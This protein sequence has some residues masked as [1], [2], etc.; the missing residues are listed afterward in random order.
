MIT[1]GKVGEGNV[2]CGE[3][4]GRKKKALRDETG[5]ILIRRLLIISGMIYL[6]ALPYTKEI[7]NTDKFYSKLCST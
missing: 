3:S 7:Y 4:E 6:T 2:L 1:S 5:S